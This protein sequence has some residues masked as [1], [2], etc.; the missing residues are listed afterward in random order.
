MYKLVW[1]LLIVIFF[2][3]GLLVLQDSRQSLSGFRSIIFG[4]VPIFISILFFFLK[5][6]KAFVVVATNSLLLGFITFSIYEVFLIKKNSVT[7]NSNVAH[8]N[9]WC[10]S[11]FTSLNNLE[12]YPLGSISN[13]NKKFINTLNGSVSYRPNDRYGF[14]NDNKVWDL[15]KIHSVFIGDSFTYGADVNYFESF[16]AQYQ[17][18]FKSSINLGCEGAGPIIELAIFK[19]YVKNLKLKPKYIFWVYYGNDIAKDIIKENNS[20]YQNYLNNNFTQNLSK[21][22]KEINAIINQ[23]KIQ[24]N[25]SANNLKIDTRKKII[26]SN[27]FK[28]S[29]L[30]SELGFSHA[31]SREN[32]KI[33]KRILGEVNNEVNLWNGELIFVSI[34]SPNRYIR[35]LGILDEQSYDQN[36]KKYLKARKIESIYL[37]DEFKKYKNPLIFYSGHLNYEGN[38]ILSNLI[39]KKIKN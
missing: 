22:Q 6:K 1:K 33:F 39:I 29:N 5:N 21:R 4:Y 30:R 28:F 31:F 23:Y 25:L 17:N 20:F 38:K 18:T 12:L 35:P 7:E 24:E 13:K 8:E 19:E 37:H 2:I 27:F 14:N 10:G 11:A 16:V 32:F 26:Y 34:P 15:K 3:F 36:I 9:Q